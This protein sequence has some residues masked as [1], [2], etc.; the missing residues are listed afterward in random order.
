MDITEKIDLFL[1]EITYKKV[2]RKGKV[3]RKPICPNGFKAVNGTCV[4][5]TGQ[6]KR[7]RAKSA[8]KA[9]IANWIRCNA[10][11]LWNSGGK[12]A[13]LLKRRAKSM[14]RRGSFNVPEQPG[15]DGKNP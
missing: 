6:E 12:S 10:N 8:K 2:I 5:M 9:Q 13:K 15:T 14:R 4:K 3:I 11:K 7:K 1:N